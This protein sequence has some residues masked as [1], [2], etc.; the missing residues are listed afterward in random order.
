MPSKHSFLDTPM[1]M[2]QGKFPIQNLICGINYVMPVDSV[3][4]KG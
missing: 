1:A 3:W 2:D 4:P